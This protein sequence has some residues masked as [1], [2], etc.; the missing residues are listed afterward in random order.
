M[1]I[2]EHPELNISGGSGCDV[3]DTLTSLSLN[4]ELLEIWDTPISGGSSPEV[5]VKDALGKAL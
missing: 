5:V 4:V 2:L 3:G 1:E